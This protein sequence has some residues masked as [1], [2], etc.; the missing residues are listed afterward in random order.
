[1]S[2]EAVNTFGTLIGVVIAILGASLFAF[3]IAMVIWTFNDIRS[4]SR[5]WLAILLACLLT[6]VIPIV[7][8]ILYLMV[9]PKNT[10]AEVY[11]RA[12]EEEALLRDLESA[13]TCHHCGS[14]IKEE[15]AFCPTCHT[16]LQYSCDNCNELVRTE[17]DICAYCGADQRGTKGVPVGNSAAANQDFASS[18]FAPS[19]DLDADARKQSNNPFARVKSR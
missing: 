15:W 12:L 8:L 18:Q 11:D 4:R 9:R 13:S 19:V 5:D 6:L 7:G 2:P 16:Q 17:W 10:L 1:M 3:W 14:S